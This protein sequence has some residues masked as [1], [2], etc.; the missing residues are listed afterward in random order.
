MKRK[1]R[2][3]LEEMK[4]AVYNT[5]FKMYTKGKEHVAIEVKGC[6]VGTIY[7]MAIALKKLVKMGAIDLEDIDE[8]CNSAKAFFENESESEK[9]TT[10]CTI[11]EIKG[12]L[13]D[14]LVNLLHQVQRGEISEDDIDFEDFMRRAKEDQ[15][16]S[17]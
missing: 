2:K 6:Q 5:Q 14:E 4:K 13:A 15:D 11:A 7:K 10:H 9:I 3:E 12:D 8:I 17:L 1:T 16:N